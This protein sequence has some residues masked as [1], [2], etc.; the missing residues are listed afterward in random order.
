MTKGKYPMSV[1]EK[2][3]ERKKRRSY[4]ERK[5][6]LPAIDFFK[7]FL[8]HYGILLV[9]VPLFVGFS[10][11]EPRFIRPT[12]LLNILRW[13]SVLGLT[14]TGLTLIIIVGEFDISFM[15]IATI[16]AIL[17][18][19]FIMHGASLWLSWVLSV[20]FA[21]AIS[22]ANGFLIAYVGIPAFIVTLGTLMSLTGL[23]RALT[24]GIEIYSQKFPPGFTSIGRYM[25]AGIIPSPVIISVIVCFLMV[26][27][28]DYTAWGRHCYA[29]GLNKQAAKYMAINVR[30]TKLVAYIIGGLLFGASGI[31]MSSMFASAG[32]LMGQGYFLPTMIVSFLGA[33]FLAKG[34]PNPR[35]SIVGVII[36]AVL[37]NGFIMTNVPFWAKSIIQGTILIVTITLVVNTKKKVWK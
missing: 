1:S 29:V 31:I 22:A 32:S 13:A 11:L 18:V 15:Y 2:A 25:V 21:V 28:I 17:S 14:A 20:G 7:Y 5:T 8:S 3:N 30:R 34:I 19:V 4:R 10:V 12:N 35:G 16:A 33:T 24:G 36:L 26:I 6:H 9:L 27:L 37:A 23:S